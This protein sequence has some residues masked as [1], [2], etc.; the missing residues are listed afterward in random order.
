MPVR[1]EKAGILPQNFFPAISGNNG[2]CRIHSQNI[3][4]SVSD[5]NAFERVFENL[6][7]QL[8]TQFRLHPVID[9]RPKSVTK[10]FNTVHVLIEMGSEFT[11]LAT[12]IN[13]GPHIQFPL[14]EPFAFCP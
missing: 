11:D 1:L 10:F 14:P 4:F 7:I 6:F 12:G 3:S 9:F 13:I 8:K 5:G 2:K